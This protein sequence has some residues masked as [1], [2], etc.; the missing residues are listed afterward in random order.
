MD[1]VKAK[2]DSAHKL[3]NKKVSLA[4]D[5]EAVN[6][7]SDKGDKEDVNF[8]SSTDFHNQRSENQGGKIKSMALVINEQWIER[9]THSQ[10]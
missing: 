6:V 10:I 8:I 2:L 4:Q 9:I 3:L 7:N 5:V 1:E